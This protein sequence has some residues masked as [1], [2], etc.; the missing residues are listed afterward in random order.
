[1]GDLPGTLL[2]S[3]AWD[4]GTQIAR[5]LS[6]AKSRSV[7]RSTSATP[8]AALTARQQR[9]RQRAPARLLPKGTDLSAH[10]VEHLLAVENELNAHPRIA[11]NDRPPQDLFD[12][13]IAC[14]HQATVATFA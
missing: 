13:L 7:S 12:A 3:I 4:Q 14:Q 5:H 9:E 11:P 6:I 10:T 1:M 8:T 2:R